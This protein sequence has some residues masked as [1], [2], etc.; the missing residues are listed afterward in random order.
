MDDY[1]SGFSD[2]VTEYGVHYFVFFYYSAQS[3]AS[4]EYWIHFMA[5]FGGVHAGG[6]NSVQEPF[7]IFLRRL[8]RVDNTADNANITQSQG[9]NHESRDTT[10][11]R[12]QEVNSLCT[13]ERF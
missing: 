1:L 8:T 4:V 12:L 13:F 5:C 3:Q 6:Y 7:P 10:P 11:R 9:A 2:F